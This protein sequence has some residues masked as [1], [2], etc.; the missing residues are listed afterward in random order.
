MSARAS[1]QTAIQA[2]GTASNIARKDE[3]ISPAKSPIKIAVLF[4][5]LPRCSPV[6]MP[7]I[8]KN[9]LDQIRQ[10]GSASTVSHLH[11][12]YR[13][14]RVANPRSNENGELST[15]NYDWFVNS[16][17]LIEEPGAA[18]PAELEKVM[19][20]GDTYGD[21]GASLR[22]LLLQLHSLHSVTTLFE[23]GDFD[24]AVFLRPDLEYHDPIPKKAVIYA[25][26]HPK[27]CV[28]PNWQSWGGCNDRFAI[29][30]KEAALAYGKRLSEVFVYCQDKQ[31]PLHSEKLL[32]YVVRKHHLSLRTMATR[33]SR[34]RI[35]GARK[36]ESFEIFKSS[37]KGVLRKLRLAYLE[38]IS[39]L[40]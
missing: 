13:Q 28:V 30:G 35:D 16:R 39:A 2:T 12:L 40:M 31:Q 24:V 29:C 32:K 17:G 1:A 23:Q 20:F 21:E 15:D 22:N 37:P 9:V 10:L 3:K 19:A 8:E 7:S 14:S 18:P 5:G 33:A 25:A 27:A 26:R 4:F 11:H 34:V 36:D 6:C 38:A